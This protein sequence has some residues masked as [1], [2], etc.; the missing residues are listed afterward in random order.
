MLMV[1]TTET[2]GRAR[3]ARRRDGRSRSDGPSRRSRSPA[4]RSAARCRSPRF[5]RGVLFPDTGTVQPARLVRTLRRSRA[6]TRRL[7]ARGNRGDRGRA[8]S[9]T[10]AARHGARRAD[11]RRHQRRDDGLAAGPRTADRVRQLRRA[12]RAGAGAARQIGWTGGEAIVDGAHVPALLPHD[13][14]RPRADGQR[15][16][17]DRRGNRID[18]RFTHDDADR[19][20]RRARAAP[21]AARAG[22]GAGRA[23]RG[24]ARSTCRPTTCRSS[25]ARRAAASTS[26]PATAGNGVGPSWLAGQALASLALGR[27]DEWSTPAARPPPR[28]PRVPREPFRFVG[29]AA[30]RAAI[31]ACEEADEA[32]RREPLLARAVGAL[33]RLLGMN[34]G[35]R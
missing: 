16:G 4:P 33:P 35:T 8:G 7:A 22:R 21:P 9:V 6:R 23:A 12:D 25:A 31:L 3:R 18:R 24:A 10:T 29:G 13:E 27:D 26:P 5:R 32:G 11:R 19:G 2:A 30:I 34:V 14:R 28:R 17:A 15:L 1:A 20:P